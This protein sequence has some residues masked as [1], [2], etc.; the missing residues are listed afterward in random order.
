MTMESGSRK[1]LRKTCSMCDATVHVKRAMCGCGHAFTLKR[2]AR[3]CVCSEPEK[4]RK[5]DRVRKARGRSTETDQQTL[6]RQEQNR[7]R[8]ASVRASETC[9][10]T[11]QR[12]EQNRTRMASVRASETCEQTLQRQE[13]NRK[14]MASVR[15][16]ETCEQ[17]L[18]KQEQNRTCMASVRA[19]ET[20]EQTLQRQERNKKCMASVRASETCEQTL[21]GQER[22][23]KC[24][25]STRERSVTLEAALS[26]FQ[27]EVKLGP[28][29][30]WT[31]CHRMMH[32][33]SVVLC[34]RDKY[35][36]VG[37]DVLNNVLSA[38]LK[39]I[40]CNGNIWICKTC[41]RSLKRGSMPVQAKAN[42]LQL[43]E[44][45]AE[46]SDLNALELRLICL[47]LPFMKMVALPS[48]KQRSIH[49]PAVNVPAKVDTICN[50]LPRL[51][52]QTEL[53][54]LK[55]KR[56]LAYRGHYM[57]GYVI[58]QKALN[59][60]RFLKQHNPLYASVEVNHLW[61]DQ[62]LADSEEELG[63]SLVEP[64]EEV[65]TDQTQS[66]PVYG[67]NPSNAFSDA[68]C[69]LETLAHQSGFLIHTVPADGNCMFAAVSHQLQIS[70]VKSVD[71]SELRETVANHLEANSALYWNAVS[72]PVVSH[73]AYNADTEPPTAEDEYISSVADP[74]LRLQLE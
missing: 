11:L 36:K 12:Q 6:Q 14:C 74:Q 23:R 29:F 70:G 35:T 69:K 27:S 71:S 57:Y 38:D 52:S 43:S 65:E 40:S 48:G 8:M 58:P 56:K 34:N 73:D 3:C 42:G 20:C 47:R 31:C 63:S 54:P 18:Q 64:V 50:V 17:T 41:D 32:K 66:E 4:K 26:T 59:A 45:P 33:K 24:M 60:L 10:Q 30:V 39:Y 15:A 72:E 21:Q 68:M 2:K 46:L 28:N 51:P 25:A 53:V 62:S 19:S 61:V 5:T 16:S 67:L 44:I 37:A 7:T 1:C 49:G 9:E 22:N 13:R 55:L